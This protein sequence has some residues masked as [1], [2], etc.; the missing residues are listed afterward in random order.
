LVRLENGQ[1][2]RIEGAAEVYFSRIDPVRGGA[3]L[4]IKAP[5]S[6]KIKR[7]Y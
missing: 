7:I 3:T 1:G 5:K 2:I 6:V 4:A